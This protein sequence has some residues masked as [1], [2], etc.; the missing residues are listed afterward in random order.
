MEVRDKTAA[1]RAFLLTGITA[2]RDRK[3]KGIRLNQSVGN[4]CTGRD[5][6]QSSFPV[7]GN[8]GCPSIAQTAKRTRSKRGTGSTPH[9]P[10]LIVLT[11]VEGSIFPALYLE[12][13]LSGP[14][15]VF[16]FC[17]TLLSFYILY[18]VE[19]IDLT[20]P[21]RHVALRRSLEKL[22][23]FITTPALFGQGVLERSVAFYP[24]TRSFP[25]VRFEKE[26]CIYLPT[27]PA[28]SL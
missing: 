6:I 13:A 2:S 20:H 3:H 26:I 21:F 7:Y 10:G 16:N 15:S 12:F 18:F 22:L 17:S 25:V 24:R 1:D 8:N 11:V 14:A 9:F 23:A 28:L 19:L 5:G 4:G 27:Y